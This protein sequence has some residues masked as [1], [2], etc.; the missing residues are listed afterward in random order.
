MVTYVKRPL[1]VLPLSLFIKDDQMYFLEMLKI[2]K[3]INP[4]FRNFSSSDTFYRKSLNLGSLLLQNFCISAICDILTTAPILTSGIECVRILTFH[5]SPA[6]RLQT[7]FSALN[8]CW[9]LSSLANTN[10]KYNIYVDGNLDWQTQIQIILWCY[11]CIKYQIYC[12][13]IKIHSSGCL[14]S[15]LV[16]LLYSGMDGWMDLLSAGGVRYS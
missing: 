8:T 7:L 15:C 9:H 12:T 11:K 6:G 3:N 4:F 16:G 10:T 13:Q 5:G 14:N 1:L 2:L